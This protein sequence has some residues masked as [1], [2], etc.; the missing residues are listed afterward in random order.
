ME[1]TRYWIWPLLLALLLPL[2]LGALPPQPP[3]APPLPNETGGTGSPAI[4]LLAPTDNAYLK[5]NDVLFTFNVS[6]GSLE[7]CT[8]LLA[9]SGTEH[10]LR[11]FT[12]FSALPLSWSERNLADGSYA[13][14]V[15]CTK[16]GSGS[17][18]SGSRSFT[19]DTAKP[20]LV[21]AATAR[22]GGFL[23]LNGSH[24][25]PGTVQAN[26]SNGS[27]VV[28]QWTVDVL[29]D[30]TFAAS[31]PVGYW[32]P[33]GEYAVTT[34][35]EGYADAKRSQ[36]FTLEAL[37]AG[38]TT[39]SDVY[40]PGE[41]V[42]ITLDGFRAYS[43][44]RLTVEKPGAGT[45][46]KILSTDRDGSSSFAYAL[47]GT[48]PTGS[49]ALF[50]QDTQYG[51]LNATA[52]FSLQQQDSTDD[53]WDKDGVKNAVDNCPVK[54]NPDQK[55]TDGDGHGDACDATPNGG[56]SGI[57][58]Y[59]KDGVADSVDN[60]P[61]VP[62][63]DQAD[64]DGDGIGD[65]CDTHDDSNTTSP[66]N[67]PGVQSPAPTGG[68]PL[69]LVVILAVLLLVLGTAGYL[70]YDGKLVLTDLGGSLRALFQPEAKPPGTDAS[71]S[72][73]DMQE[74]LRHFVFSE[75]S[76][77]YDDLT[78]RNALIQRGWGEKEVDALFERIYAE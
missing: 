53:D 23:G 12:D 52:S 20:V 72:G 64:T 38:M 67:L 31:E 3:Q 41:T 61:T 11:N 17:I 57:A 47:T 73:P 36:T 25:L 55:D 58:D 77:G 37:I 68:F 51:T 65:A 74:E 78:I 60:C 18:E 19:I 35:Q 4:A 75:R 46:E 27:A 13:W 42:T 7:R 14:S 71:F 16:T 29:D 2:L 43:S 33:P 59:D 56:S 48:R 62:N 22:Q 30:G 10:A 8:L 34:S 54:A 44:V 1:R 39:D 28:D 24:Y 32:L 49:Y 15:S 5:E 40:F 76:R 63:P 26:L 50:A 9:K 6:V 66:P 70:V 45:Y 21:A 69:L